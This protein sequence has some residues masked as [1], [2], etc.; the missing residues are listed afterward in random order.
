[1]KRS[2][3][4]VLMLLVLLMGAGC[5]GTKSGGSG[6]CPEWFTMLPED[7]NYLFAAATATSLRLQMAVERAKLAAR[8]DL[9]SQIEVR[10]QGLRKAFDEEVGLG[11]DAEL[12]SSYTQVTKEVISQTLNGARAREQDTMKEG[13]VWRACVLM[14]LPIGAANAA[15]VDKI[16]ANKAMYTRFRA[17]QAF[18]DLEKEVEKYEEYKEKQGM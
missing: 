18:D 1:M 11:E 10:I 13:T 3:F 12:L 16:K 15:L 5:A 4:A 14:E 2:H 9:S 7:P 17:S 8:N 6:P